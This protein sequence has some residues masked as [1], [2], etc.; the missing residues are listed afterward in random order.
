MLYLGIDV[1]KRA[2]EAALLDDAGATVWRHRI[3]ASRAGFAAFEQ[4]LAGV[5]FA[6][7]TVALE[8]TGVYWLALHTWLTERGAARVVVLNPLQTRAFRN[9]NLRG[10]KT[11]RIDAVA[12]ATLVRWMGATLSDHVRPDDRQAAAR[13]VGRLR[14]EIIELRARQLVK[15]GGVLDRLFPE[16]RA[17]FGKLGCASALAVLARW[18]SPAALGA[19]DPTEL[20]A[21][22][23]RASRGSLG[24]A[25]AAELQVLAAT[26]AGLPDPLDAVGVAVRTLVGHVEH[27]DGQIAALGARLGELLA[28]DAASEALLRSCPGIGVDT[29]RTWLAEAP[30]LARVRGKDGADKL[31]ALVGLDA[32]LKQSG[33]S[34]G[35]VRMS[36]R[37][38]RYLRRSLMLAAESA[39]RTDPQCRAI[40]EKQRAKGKHYRVAV[41]HVARKLVHILYAV[42]TH[43]RPYTIPAAYAAAAAT[44]PEVLVEA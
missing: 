7:L 27:L 8:A 16:F 15:L 25:K 17:A 1:G 3:A 19:A 21:V 12:L 32:Q 13:D 18:T 24:A 6:T 20:A 26:S 40:L 44:P 34:A 35:R 4:H 28:P 43:E 9:A 22:L 31:V 5:D 38:N 36:K 41:S 14:T 30:P 10:T 42:L 2:H 37:G 11:D 29:A 39:A 23:A 33:A